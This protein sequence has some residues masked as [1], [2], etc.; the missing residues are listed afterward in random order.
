MNDELDVGHSKAGSFSLPGA[1]GSI[2]ARGHSTNMFGCQTGRHES[3]SER[4][5]VLI[6]QTHIF[7]A[8]D[9]FRI[10]KNDTLAVT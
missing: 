2:I 8:L 5:G 3:I 4:I 1:L 6:V 9:A 7:P 10:Q